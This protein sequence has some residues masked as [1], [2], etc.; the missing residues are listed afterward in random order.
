MIFS[1]LIVVQTAV[2][3]IAS[4]YLHMQANIACL[5]WRRSH[6]KYRSQYDLKLVFVSF[7]CR[8]LNSVKFS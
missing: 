7:S 5:G 2:F 6:P 3:A 4:L 1:A 8:Q